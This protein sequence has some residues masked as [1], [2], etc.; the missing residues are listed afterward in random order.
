MGELSFGQ[1][2]G[3]SAATAG[4]QAGANGLLGLAGARLAYKY[5]KKLM[6]KQNQYNIEAFNRENARQDSLI[7]NQYVMNKEALRAA[8]LSE[9]MA[10]TDATGISAPSATNM[11]VPSNPS[12]SAI[13]LGKF[14][15]VGAANANLVSSQAELN[16]VQANVL[17]KKA[18]AEI[19]KM[20][21]DIKVALDTL[22][23]TIENIKADTANKLSSK[24][25][26]EKQA[27][28]IEKDTDKLAEV[29]RGITIDNDWKVK[30]YQQD[31]N[32]KAQEIIGLMKDNRIKEAEA[33]LADMGI[34]L[35]ADGLTTLIG[36]CASG[37]SEQIM[38]QLSEGFAQLISQLPEA[39]SNI[40]S[41]LWN[42][43][44]DSVTGAAK[45]AWNWIR[46]KTG[47]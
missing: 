24:E 42:A 20:R 2:L 6:A 9:S 28:F 15:L 11:D 22:P 7:R 30:N 31:Y 26:N 12:A 29:I 14:D 3:Q 40:M 1:Q 27:K 21:A 19:D 4:V 46:E 47:L 32:K 41:A 36:V 17:A 33:K 37:H 18:D 45:G 34:V 25:V 5:N 10:G 44:K 38:S 35:G 43:G 16:R 8:G 23:A 13:D 39:I